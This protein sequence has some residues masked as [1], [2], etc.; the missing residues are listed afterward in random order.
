VKASQAFC[1]SSSEKDVFFFSDASTIF[2]VELLFSSSFFS[3]NRSVSLGRDD[4]RLVF[5]LG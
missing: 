3:L 5:A 2:S 4:G 1:S